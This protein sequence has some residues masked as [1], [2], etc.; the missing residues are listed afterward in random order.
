MEAQKQRTPQDVRAEWNR[1]GIS[2]R[3]WALQHGFSPVT[4]CQVING[5]NSGAIGIGHR[6]AVSLGIKHGDIDAT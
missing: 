6:I 2:M 1:K 3:K 5:Q 4:V